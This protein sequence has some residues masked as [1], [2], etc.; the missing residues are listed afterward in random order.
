MSFER[1]HLGAQ[2]TGLVL[3]IIRMVGAGAAA[4]TGEMGPRGEPPTTADSIGVTL[5]RTGV[6]VYTVAYGE[7]PGKLVS[8]WW[9]HGHTV[10]TAT[11]PRV[12][13]IDENS[14]DG[15]SNTLNFIT[16]TPATD[17]AAAAAYELT[18]S[19]TVCLYLLFKQTGSGI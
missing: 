19:D 1:Y 7:K 12:V 9:A 5:G 16:I 4:P 11:T 15:T 6:G 3:H 13:Q 10:P 2:P 8:F 18:T 17:L 14:M